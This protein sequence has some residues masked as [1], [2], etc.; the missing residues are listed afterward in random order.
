MEIFKREG[1]LRTKKEHFAQV[2]IEPEQLAKVEIISFLENNQLAIMFPPKSL[3]CI[4]GWHRL[5][6][7]RKLPFNEH[8]WPVDLYV[9]LPGIFTIIIYLTLY[10]TLAYN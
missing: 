2:L 7:A 5:V 6:V 3:K 10:L 4:H 1:C 8:W 9:R